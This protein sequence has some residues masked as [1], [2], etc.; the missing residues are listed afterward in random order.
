MGFS[1][2]AKQGSRETSHQFPRT[3]AVI[4]NVLIKKLKTYEITEVLPF[5][6]MGQLERQSY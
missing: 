3:Y 2:L 5:M 4:A 6:V 1:H